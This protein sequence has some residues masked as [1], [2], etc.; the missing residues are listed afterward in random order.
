M[1]KKKMIKMGQKTDWATLNLFMPLAG[2]AALLLGIYTGLNGFMDGFYGGIQIF[3]ILTAL[4]L[5]V[6]AL[7]YG[8]TLG[9]KIRRHKTKANKI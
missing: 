3:I 8:K 1:N 2:T 7:L 6:R 5:V 4:T 9:F